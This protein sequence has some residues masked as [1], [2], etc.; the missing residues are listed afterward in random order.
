MHSGLPFTHFCFAA[1]VYLE[2]VL[3]ISNNLPFYSVFPLHLVLTLISFRSI[4]AGLRGNLY[5]YKRGLFRELPLGTGVALAL[6][7]FCRLKRKR[8]EVEL[9]VPAA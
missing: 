3:L 8:T 5:V 1:F 7:L 6:G 9:S 4:P 2:S